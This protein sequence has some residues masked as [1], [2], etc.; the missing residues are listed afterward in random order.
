MSQKKIRKLKKQRVIVPN[1]EVEVSAKNE[2]FMEILK[3]NWKFLTGLCLEIFVLYLNA[4]NGAF[5]SD[6]YATIPQNPLIG[7]FSNSLKGSFISI[8]NWLVYK[9][10]GFGSPLPF[11]LVSLVLYLS[12][13]VL[14]FVLLYMI[15]NNKLLTQ[16]TM[17]LFAVNPLHV[18]AVSWI[19]GKPYLISP[20]TV[21]ITL[22]IFV[23]YLKSGNKKLILPLLLSTAICFYSE[24]VRFFSLIFLGLLYILSYNWKGKNNINWIKVISIS[25]VVVVMVAILIYPAVMVRI[26]A[27]NSGTN[28][29]GSIFYDPFFQ[30]PTSMAKYL[31]LIWFPIDLTLYHT[32]YIFPNWLNWAILLSYLSMLVYFYFKNKNY[33]FALAFI[34]AAAAPSMAPVKVSWLVA[35]RYMF[36]GS[37]G[38]SL[39]LGLTILSLSKYLKLVPATLFVSLVIFSTVRTWTRNIDWQ[40]NHNLWVNT[41]QV[42]PNSHNAWNNIGDDYDK[43][44]DY[45]SAIKGFTQ[46]T[47]VKPNYADAFHNRANIFYKVGRLDLARESYETAIRL[48]PGLFQTYMS[49]VQIDLTLKDKELALKDAGKLLELSVDNPQSWYIMGVVQAQVGNLDEAKTSMKKCLELNPQFK[50][51]SDALLQLS[52]QT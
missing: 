1:L 30:Y 18:E 25:T 15:T 44:R 7:S 26:N 22:I 52:S 24:K 29:S 12:V 31:Q 45:A 48:N 43:L 40:S 5:V 32:M 13:I 9:L 49:L 21:M 35:E 6:D 16:I 2:G 38:F 8:L 4:L 11:H 3:S 14:G 17:I 27:V 46:S 41:C 50:P 33:F 42:S 37:L 19:S 10:F 39:F 47:I 28:A 20:I 36:F 51:A 34:F 23:Q